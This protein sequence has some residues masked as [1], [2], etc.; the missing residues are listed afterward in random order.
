MLQ[1]ENLI[2]NATIENIKTM[3]TFCVRGERF[4]DGLR[5]GMLE[6][7]KIIAI[8]KRLEMLSKEFKLLTKKSI[9]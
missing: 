3:F 6:N 7:G 8:L 9:S 4:C 2:K 1:D 5:A